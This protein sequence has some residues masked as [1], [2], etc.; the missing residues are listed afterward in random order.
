MFK[1]QAIVILVF[2]L[3]TA[4]LTACGQTASDAEGNT[5][6][7]PSTA[8]ETTQAPDTTQAPASTAQDDAQLK[9]IQD[10]LL[11]SANE[12]TVTESE[13]TFKDDSGRDAITIKKNPKRVAVLYGSHA[14]LYT[15]A[16]GKVSLGVSSAELYKEQIGRDIMKDEGVVTVAAS[17]AGKNWD[18]EAIL[19][20]QPDLIICSTAMSGYSTIAAPAE[21]VNIPVIALTYSGVTDYLRWF[22]VFCNINSKPELWDSIAVKVADDI[23]NIILK[24]QKAEHKPQI[25]ALSPGTDALSAMLVGS[26]MGAIIDQLGGVNL[27]EGTDPKLTTIDIDLEKMYA[28]KPEMIF[29]RCGST[30]KEVGDALNKLVEGNPVWESMDA[31]KDGKVYLMPKELYLYRPNS[32]YAESY[33]MLAERLYPD[34]EF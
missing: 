32:R 21:A 12:V 2:L 11:E 26:D 8:A 18:V 29:V 22:K 17:S 15:E 9:A 1:R 28:L 34:I 5:T 10:M 25:L 24:T 31:V 33:K 30:E 14:C 27:A 13:V 6:Q 20:Q 23:A 3:I 7:A 4:L 19:A 16:G